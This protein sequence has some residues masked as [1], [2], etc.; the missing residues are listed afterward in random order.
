MGTTLLE[1]P[2]SASEEP[3]KHWTRTEYRRLIETGFLQD[4]KYELVLGEIIKKMGQGR[5]HIIIA[6]RI[7]QGAGSRFRF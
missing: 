7:N 3:R 1:A 5:R 6:M 4:G 2:P